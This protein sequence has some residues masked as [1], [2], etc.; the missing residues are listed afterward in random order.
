MKKY[1]FLAIILAVAGV[2]NSC[3]DLDITPYTEIS[4]DQY[5]A[6]ATQIQSAVFLPYAWMREN[7]IPQAT[8]YWKNEELSSDQLAWPQKG[9]HGYDGG[10]HGRQHYHSWTSAVNDNTTWTAWQKTYQGIGYCNNVLA[11]LEKIDFTQ[12]QGLTPEDKDLFVN[13]LRAVRAWYYL[14]MVDSY[15]NVP[16]VTSLEE[17]SPSQTSRAEGFNWV[18]KELLEVVDKLPVL[19][20]GNGMRFTKAAVYAILA[21]MYLNAEVWTGTARLDDC[22]KYCDLLI[23][24]QAGGLNGEMALDAD[25]DVTYSN[26]NASLARESIFYIACNR[27]QNAWFNRNDVGTYLERDILNTNYGGNNGI[28]V[29]PGVIQRYD[30][31]DLRRYSWFMYGIGSGYGPYTGVKNYMGPYKDI[32][33]KLNVYCIGTEEFSG[34]PIIYVDKPVKS[35]IEVSG[36]SS[37]PIEQRRVTIKEWYSPEF[38]GEEAKLLMEAAYNENPTKQLLIT[39]YDKGINEVYNSGAYNGGRPGDQY[40]W[41]RMND[42]RFMWQDCA[43]NT[44][45]RFLKYKTGQQTDADFANNQFV[46][47][48]LSEIYFAKAEALMRKNGNAATAE[49]VDLINAVKKRAFLPEVWESQEAISEGIRYTTATLT[50][51]ELLT[52]RGREFIFEGKRRRDLIRFD[53]W[54]F[55]IADWWDGGDV[56]YAN[57][58]GGS[59]NRDP[60]RRIFPIPGRAL[61]SNPNLVQNPGYD[62]N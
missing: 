13:E 18:E 17:G 14:R 8:G 7:F 40:S 1:S 48:R 61:Q 62:G 28:V 38:P 57:G 39:D 15:G 19:S 52:E 33:R 51:D 26:R 53:K 2:F 24:G 6:D 46:V 41:S 4:T 32:G 16:I 44:G 54:E 25:I 42:Y 29:Q 27:G 45:P 22:I 47:Y 11:D 5:Y 34:K 20:N 58:S 35:V 30:D 49:V 60:S 3:T 50:M 12:I 23:S 31:K 36:S 56:E 59:I 37:T 21:E 10:D 43:E 9:R 55:A